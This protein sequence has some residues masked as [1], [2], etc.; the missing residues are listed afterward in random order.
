MSLAQL[1]IDSGL[2]SLVCSP[3]EVVALRQRFPDAF[4]VTPGVRMGQE[5]RGDQSRICDPTTALR[6]GASALVVGRPICES[7][8]PAQAAKNYY[9]EIQKA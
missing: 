7:L 3:E 2:S 8:D 4:L 6:R 9:E 5:D 1:A